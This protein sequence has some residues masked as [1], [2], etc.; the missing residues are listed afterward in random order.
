VPN[1]LPKSKYP[2]TWS[3]IIGDT[4]AFNATWD[5]KNNNNK[6]PNISFFL[7]KKNTKKKFRNKELGV[8][9]HLAKELPPMASQGVVECT[10]LHKY[11]KNLQY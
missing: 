2:P 9:G 4:Y 6:L 8:A 5:A 10:V 3:Y 11:Q 7:K 1:I